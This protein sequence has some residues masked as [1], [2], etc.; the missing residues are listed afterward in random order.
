MQKTVNQVKRFVKVFTVV[1]LS[2]FA[3]QSASAQKIEFA[4]EK[5]AV[6][7]HYRFV[8]DQ[9]TKRSPAI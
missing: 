1:A 7:K 5:K 2:G 6:V 8:G 3:V 4:K 9:M